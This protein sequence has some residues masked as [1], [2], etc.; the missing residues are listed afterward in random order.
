MLA[1]KAMRIELRQKQLALCYALLRDDSELAAKLTPRVLAL[2]RQTQTY[3]LV[4]DE[5]HQC[6]TFPISSN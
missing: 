5:R 2:I 1:P 6:G 4:Q 3:A